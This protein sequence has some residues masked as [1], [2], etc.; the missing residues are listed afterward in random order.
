[1][2]IR[3]TLERQRQVHARRRK[4]DERTGMIEREVLVGFGPKLFELLRVLAVHPPRREDVDVVE[5]RL[6]AVLILQTERDDVELQLSDRAQDQ[7]VI[8]QRTKDLR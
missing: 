7:V 3:P 4:I 5:R 6:D 8:A 1:I 2:E